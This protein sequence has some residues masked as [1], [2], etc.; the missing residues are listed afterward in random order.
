M[1]VEEASILSRLF[2]ARRIRVG[3]L[4]IRIASTSHKKAHLDL[5]E[6]EQK[7]RLRNKKVKKRRTPAIGS[8]KADQCRT[9]RHGLRCEIK[10]IPQGCEMSKCQEKRCDGD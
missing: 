9:I 10:P 3:C 7:A 5:A 4:G 1:G 8:E 6:N 2:S